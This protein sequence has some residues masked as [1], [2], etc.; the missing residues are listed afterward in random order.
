MC[1]GLVWEAIVKL[2]R[3]LEPYSSSRLFNIFF[4]L[5]EDR[6]EVGGFDRGEDNVV[7]V[8]VVSSGYF[9]ELSF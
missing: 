4:K 2:L 8:N 7:G 9:V 6:I 3:F 1:G 5:G